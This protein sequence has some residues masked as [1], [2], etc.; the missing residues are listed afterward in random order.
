MVV[1]PI[2][3][4]ETRVRYR[5]RRDTSRSA[6]ATKL[7][8]TKVEDI[9]VY[10]D[11]EVQDTK[12]QSRKDETIYTREEIRKHKSRDDCWL[13]VEN[14]VYDVSKYVAIH[15]GGDAILSRA[16]EDATEGFNGPQHPPHARATLEQFRIGRLGSGVYL[17]FN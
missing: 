2:H 16:G 11:D 15:P 3:G 8:S 1:G 4:K 5:R 14:G 10:D 12:T 7:S 9:K 6:P 17:V 13:I